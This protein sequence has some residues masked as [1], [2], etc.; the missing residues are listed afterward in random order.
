M[1]DYSNFNWGPTSQDFQEVVTKEYNYYNVYEK[2]FEVEQGDIVLDI[3]ASVGDF[4]WS[5]LNKNPKHCWAIEPLK[6]Y[7]RALMS[8]CYG[9]QVS[10]VNAAISDK[11]TIEIYWDGIL[12][13]PKTLS[14]EEL[15]SEFLIEKVDFMKV[16]CE[17]GEYDIFVESNLKYLL[18]I[19]K[20]VIEFHLDTLETKL[21]FRRFRDNIIPKFKKVIVNSVDGVDI[22]WDLNNEHFLEYYNQI[23]VYIDN[24]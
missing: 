8:N 1:V 3:G 20:I 10:F 13:K 4:I 5:I 7:Y 19:K 12:E 14:F 21:Q 11:K 15:I 2:H 22:S 6:D 17:G 23:I 16:D 9:K 18:E 24:R